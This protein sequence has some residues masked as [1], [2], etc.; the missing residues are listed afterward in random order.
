M[1]SKIAGVFLEVS[2]RNARNANPDAIENIVY[3]KLGI[4]ED[5]T[6]RSTCEF[7]PRILLKPFQRHGILHQLS[8]EEIFCGVRNAFQGM[9]LMVRVPLVNDHRW[10]SGLALVPSKFRI[11]SLHRGRILGAQYVDTNLLRRWR[12]SCNSQQH[13]GCRHNPIQ[14]ILA[15]TPPA[16]LI[17]T[18]SMCLIPGYENAS[19]VALIYVWGKEPFFQINRANIHNLQV[20]NALKCLHK[21]LGV[22]RTISD[23]ML[24][25]Q[26]LGERYL[27]V[28][29]VCIVQDDED[30]KHGQIKDMVSIYDNASIT[31]MAHQGE[32]ANYG[33]RGLRGISLP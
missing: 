5:I 24:V 23:A 17:D 1:C 15:K 8:K 9:Y 30:M 3:E 33:L 20:S 11:Q 28:D 14:Y 4:F 7:H 16:Y 31:I 32:D 19:Y 25:V 21:K 27:W 13:G 22:P 29:A 18:W 10:I 26:L 12:R 2:R 6:R